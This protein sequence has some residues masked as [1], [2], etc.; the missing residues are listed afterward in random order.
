MKFLFRTMFRSLCM[1]SL[2]LYLTACYNGN[3]N[4]LNYSDSKKIADYY[5]EAKNEALPLEAY[6]DAFTQLEIMHNNKTDVK[7]IVSDSCINNALAE[8]INFLKNS[9]ELNV[10]DYDYLNYLIT[11]SVKLVKEALSWNFMH[12]ENFSALK[13]LNDIGDDDELAAKALA[14]LRKILD[15]RYTILLHKQGKLLPRTNKPNYVLGGFY[16]GYGLLYDLKTHQVMCYFS[17]R[18]NNTSNYREDYAAEGRSV[19][20]N[21]IL[22]MESTHHTKLKKIIAERLNLESFQ[23]DLG[24]AE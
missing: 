24:F 19:F 15:N 5:K 8:K 16:N 13:K 2:L 3:D 7:T 23:I 1:V 9:I 12:S 18:I 22:E 10:I 17:Y 14:H 21:M 6:K 11:D 20:D 4:T